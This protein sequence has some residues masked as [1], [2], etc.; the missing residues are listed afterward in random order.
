MAI[1]Q[2]SNGSHH[3][4]QAKPWPPILGVLTTA[5]CGYPATLLN[6]PR[7]TRIVFLSDVHLTF[8][9]FLVYL[10]LMYP[11]VNY[12]ENERSQ[13]FLGKTLVFTSYFYGR[14]PGKPAI[15]SRFYGRCSI[16]RLPTGQIM[17]DGSLQLPTV[18]RLR[19]TDLGEPPPSSV[20]AAV[21]PIRVLAAS[22]AKHGHY[23][24]QIYGSTMDGTSMV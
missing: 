12:P 24:I 23:Q 11:L 5:S 19:G 10:A 20:R 17:E 1:L 14:N 6:I 9:H 13:H 3:G 15:S 22:S 2:V 18:V 21:Q 8:T 7:M 4:Q 16:P